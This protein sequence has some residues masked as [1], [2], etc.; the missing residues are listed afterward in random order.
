MTVFFELG[1]SPISR[2][3]EGFNYKFYACCRNGID[4]FV[5]ISSSPRKKGKGTSSFAAAF[6]L[7]LVNRHIK[8]GLR[9]FRSHGCMFGIYLQLGITFLQEFDFFHILPRNGIRLLLPPP[10]FCDGLE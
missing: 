1:L 6:L 10:I 2:M 9:F 8:R 5:T 7:S 3:P 4:I